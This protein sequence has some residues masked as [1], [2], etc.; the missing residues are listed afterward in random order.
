MGLLQGYELSFGGS[1]GGTQANRWSIYVTWPQTRCVETKNVLYDNFRRV[2]LVF[3]HLESGCAKW[4]CCRGM[5]C[6]LGALMGAPMVTDG[7]YTSPGH[8][9][10][11][12]RQQNVIYDNFRKAWLVFS[13]WPQMHSR[14]KCDVILVNKKAYQLAH[15]LHFLFP[16]TP[17]MVSDVRWIQLGHLH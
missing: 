17:W 8:R 7:R 11:G 3:I 5:Y 4:V 14:R 10:G 2:W 6:R 1:D 16:S 9:R 13:C 12:L 15:Y